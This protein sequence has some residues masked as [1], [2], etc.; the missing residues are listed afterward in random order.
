L[1]FCVDYGRFLRFAV[2]GFFLLDNNFLRLLLLV[3]TFNWHFR[4]FCFLYLRFRAGGERDDAYR[5][6]NL[7][8]GALKFNINRTNF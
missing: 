3:R 4:H 2:V 5:A 1:F 8:R 7:T 6:L